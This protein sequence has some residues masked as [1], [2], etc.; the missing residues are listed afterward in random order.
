M[1][2]VERKA[3]VGQYL[4]AIKVGATF[5]PIVCQT[6]TNLSQSLDVVDG[7]SKCGEDKQPGQYAT[8]ELTGTGQI[9]LGYDA[10]E[11]TSEQDLQ[12]LFDN[13]TPFDWQLGPATGTA[14][15]GDVTRTGK[16]FL[17][18][19]DIKYPL[20]DI[21]TFDFTVSVQGTPVIAVTPDPAP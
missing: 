19:L 8:R 12:T 21:P 4:L 2:I 17:S 20:K 6:D 9:L 3:P 5:I 11:K 15:P 7:D 10:D 18:K 13:K 1:A 14:E 16:G